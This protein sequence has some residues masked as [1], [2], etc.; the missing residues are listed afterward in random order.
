ME[1]LQN[2]KQFTGELIIML[3][4]C[5]LYS[6]SADIITSISIIPGSVVGIGKIL[7][8]IWGIPVGMTNLIINIP[9]LIICVSRFGKK[10]LFY[11]TGV[12][13]TNSL[14]MLLLLPYL[15]SIPD[16]FFAQLC[17]AVLGGAV[18][19]LACGLIMRVGGSVG[20]STAIVRVLKSHF[21]KLN[22]TVAMFLSDAVIILI[23]A[24]ILHQWSALLFSAILSISASLFVDIGY[25]FGRMEV[26]K[27]D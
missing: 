14:G 27:V 8:A 19:G 6:I 20:G 16:I 11:T 26:D 15:P 12:V 13:A 4:G 18:N 10:V 3:I 5:V 23:G 1:F 25:T 22:V 9:I 17:V 21:Q 24:I 7:N 2:K